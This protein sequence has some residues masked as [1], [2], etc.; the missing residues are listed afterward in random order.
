MISSMFF[1]MIHKIFY[2]KVRVPAGS[3][4]TRRLG[5]QFLIV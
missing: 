2:Y 3:V 1:L 5:R 4:E